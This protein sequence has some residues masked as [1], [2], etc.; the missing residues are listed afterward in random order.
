MKR[1]QFITMVSGAAVAPVLAPL[2]A[3]AQPS[4]RMRRISA[5]FPL[6]TDDPEQMA[7]RIALR[8]ALEN[9]GWT[10]GRGARI[11]YRHA[12]SADDLGP[13]AKEIVA[14]KPDL[15]F[16]QSTG[17]A[18]AVQR[19][20]RT[21]PIVF[22]NVSDPIG[23]GFVA[24]LARPGGNMT[25]LVLFEASVAG[26]WLSM[27]KEINPRLKRA[28]LMGNP[29]TSAFDYFLRAA[30]AAAPKLSI[31]VV[32]GRVETA[33]EIERAI[34]SVSR[35]PGGGLAVP[36]DQTMIRNRDLI[37]ELTARHRLPAVYAERVY[38][39]AGGLMSYS[40]ADHVEPFRQAATYIDRILHGAKPA[41]LPVQAPT[42]YSLVIN[43]R[44]AKALGLAVPSGLLVAADEVIE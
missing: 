26:K 11:D 30:E 27:L 8:L 2:T 31:E 34:E 3:R 40:I 28:A 42:K 16:A 20:T 17:A 9:I 25:G 29:K 18:A 21:I 10:D 36:P 24:S 35:A 37:I 22:T 32:P 7:R 6:G 43:R 41:D 14:Q 13:L 4:G 1:R 23:A 44:T 12:V 5:L 19:E 39:T 15:I 33:A 38:A